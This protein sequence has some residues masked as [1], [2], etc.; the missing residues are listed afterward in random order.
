MR[1]LEL[2]VLGASILS[3]YYNAT[4]WSASHV[5]H[6]KRHVISPAWAKRSR[7]AAGD[8]LPIRVGLVQNNLEKGHDV[9]MDMYAVVELSES[10]FSIKQTDMAQI[11]T[12][13]HPAMLNTGHLCR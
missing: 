6:E 12:R 3:E 1:F 8:I 9:L 13:L 4:P 5:L 11:P 7:V 10:H 2:A